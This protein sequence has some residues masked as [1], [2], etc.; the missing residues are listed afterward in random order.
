M[1]VIVSGRHLNLKD[2]LREYAE[3]KIGKLSRFY[4]RIHE[5]EL[6]FSQEKDQLSS[7]LIVR[8]DNKHTF[9]ATDTGADD[10][11]IVDSVVDKVERQL[12]RHKEKNRNH[13][14]DGK[15]E[16]PTADELADES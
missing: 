5:A 12:R 2:E 11:G 6:V 7:E 14:H 8:I 1:R 15:P 9:V 10:H 3:E 16:L 4:D 13:K